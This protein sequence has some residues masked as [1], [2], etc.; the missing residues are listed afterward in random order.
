MRLITAAYFLTLIYTEQ[1][2]Q[3]H[4]KQTRSGIISHSCL[5]SL[6]G[7]VLATVPGNRDSSVETSFS[8]SSNSTIRLR[9]IFLSSL[10]TEPLAFLMQP[11]TILL[12]YLGKNL[13]INCS[14]NDDNATVSLLHKRHSLA[15][16]T[17]RTP[18]PNKLSVQRKVFTLLNLDLR[19][20]GIYSCEA[21]D[22]ENNRILW[23]LGTG[24]LIVIQG[25][26]INKISWTPYATLLCVKPVTDMFAMG[27]RSE[28]F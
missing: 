19:D 7:L 10:Q 3:V 22:R 16:F 8:L 27:G 4:A 2:T 21:K 25:K 15:A 28:N 1:L 12:G 6:I 9:Y 20:S 5:W 13:E 26:L 11:K 18:E 24:Y 23:P 17:K 14:T